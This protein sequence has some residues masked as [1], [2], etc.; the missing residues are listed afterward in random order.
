MGKYTSSSGYIYDGEWLFGRPTGKCKIT[1][2]NGDEYEGF[3]LNGLRHGKGKL[4]EN[5]QEHGYWQND[6]IF[7]DIVIEANSGYSKEDAR[8]YGKTSVNYF[9][10]WHFLFRSLGK[11]QAQWPGLYVG[12][13]GEKSRE[14]DKRIRCEAGKKGGSRQH[15]GEGNLENFQP[16]GFMNVRLP[17]GYKYDGVFDSGICYVSSVNNQSKAPQH[18]VFTE[19]IAL[20]TPNF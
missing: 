8:S 9:T 4:Y 15:I 10:K 17:S 18:I 20:T 13:F 6:K 3:S 12:K 16:H 7:G 14:L 5:G 2:K 19:T 1:Y 11:F